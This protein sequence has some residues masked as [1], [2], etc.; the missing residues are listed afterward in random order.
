MDEPTLLRIQNDPNYIRLSQTRKTFGWTLSII[1]LVIY[2]GFIA[3]VAFA[4]NV[5]GIKVGSSITFGLILGVA[6]ILSAIVLTGI[7]V[8]RAN[9]QYDALTKAIVDASALGSSTMGVR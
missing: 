1:M 7:Y 8:W 4:P 6:V 3:L 9:A 2:Y 5:I